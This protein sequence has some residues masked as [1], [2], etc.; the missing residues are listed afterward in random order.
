MKLTQP[1]HRLLIFQLFMSTSKPRLKQKSISI[2]KTSFS[3]HLLISH[4]NA[5]TSNIS[6]QS[7]LWILSSNIVIWLN[8]NYSSWSNVHCCVLNNHVLVCITY[9]SWWSTQMVCIGSSN[10]IS[11]Y[12]TTIML[13]FRFRRR[14]YH[15]LLVFIIIDVEVI[16]CKM[17]LVV[18]V[19]F[20]QKH[21][22]F[23]TS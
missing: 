20:R 19:L 13:F 4:S 21:A 23:I 3:Q 22:K 18:S 15:F 6:L 2:N 7:Y 11:C 5:T 16:V 10:H 12:F 9:I 1:A 14:T 8:S 17:I